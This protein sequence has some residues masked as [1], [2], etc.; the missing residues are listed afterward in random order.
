MKLGN[1]NDSFNFFF[2]IGN[3]PADFDILN[4]P[5]IEYIGN[6]I[7]VDPVTSTYTWEPKYEIEIC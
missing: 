6:D 4:N 7:I 2:G 5:Y 1:Y 3:P